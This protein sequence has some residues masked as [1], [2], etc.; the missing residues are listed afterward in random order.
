MSSFRA[1]SSIVFARLSE[2]LPLI[3][4]E[5]FGT[6]YS[7]NDVKTI[8]NKIF[9]NIS[10]CATFRI[11]YVLDSLNLSFLETQQKKYLIITH[12]FSYDLFLGV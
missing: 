3:K 1:S 5:L 2:S 12:T 7:N 9:K 6:G 10:K 11:Y 4:I 8:L